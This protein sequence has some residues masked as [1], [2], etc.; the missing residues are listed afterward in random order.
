[1]ETDKLYDNVS[2]PVRYLLLPNTKVNIVIQ[3]YII[4]IYI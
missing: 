3:H 2:Y 1:M 4:Y